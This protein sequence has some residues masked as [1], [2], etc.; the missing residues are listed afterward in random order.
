MKQATG[1]M[2][3]Q[4]KPSLAFLQSEKAIPKSHMEVEG[5]L[6]SKTILKTE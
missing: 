4:S 6:H 3:S 2:E 1:L 5:T